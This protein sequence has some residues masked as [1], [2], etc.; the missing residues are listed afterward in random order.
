MPHWFFQMHLKNAYNSTI[1]LVLNKLLAEKK[2]LYSNVNTYQNASISLLVVIDITEHKHFSEL[3]TP[4]SQKY[5]FN[6]VEPR[7]ITIEHV[8]KE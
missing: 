5:C 7:N 8:P 1:K 6:V 2:K 3:M 4:A